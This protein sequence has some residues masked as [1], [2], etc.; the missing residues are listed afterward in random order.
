MGMGVHFFGHR[1]AFL[2]DILQ[3][4]IDEGIEIG[5]QSDL[6]GKVA[7]LVHEL[8]GA[9]RVTFCNTGTESVMVASSPGTGGYATQKDSS[10]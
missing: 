3:K 9:E 8:T 5:P 4:Q 1:P 10:V 2:I 7:L 6:T